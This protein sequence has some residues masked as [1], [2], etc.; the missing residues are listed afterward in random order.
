MIDLV[1]LGGGGHYKDLLY[2]CENDKYNRWN[3]VGFFDDNSSIDN[4][5]GKCSDLPNFLSKFPNTKYCISINSSAIRNELESKYGKISQAANLIHETAVIGKNCNFQNGIT[6]GPYSVLTTNISI[7]IHTH[8]NSCASIN[9]GSSIGNYVTISPG[10]RIC[11]DVSIGDNTMVGAGAV[12]INFKSI[13]KNCILGAGTVI[14]RDI[15]ENSTVVGVPGKIIN[16]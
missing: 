14:I 6:M 3:P 8:I 16:K 7:G 1:F 12:I 5:L 2:L 4:S 15:P 10:A 9:Q 11:G 13:E